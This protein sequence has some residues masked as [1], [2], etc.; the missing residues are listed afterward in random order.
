MDNWGDTPPHFSPFFFVLR[1][2]FFNTSLL[3]WNSPWA[4]LT[5]NVWGNRTRTIVSFIKA[6]MSS[7]KV[8]YHLWRTVEPSVF[9]SLKHDFSFQTFFKMSDVSRM[10]L[11]FF[12][13]LTQWWARELNGRIVLGSA[14]RSGPSCV[15]FAYSLSDSTAFLLVSTLMRIM[16]IWLI[17]ELPWGASVWVSGACV[18]MSVCV[19]WWTDDLWSP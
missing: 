10:R 3:L 14:P 11:G 17:G 19:L 15:V 1:D 8:T 13:M 18:C 16:N 7:L 12:Y 5:K 2:Y 4:L 6:V 9:K